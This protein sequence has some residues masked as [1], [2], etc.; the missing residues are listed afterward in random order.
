MSLGCLSFDNDLS[1]KM[2]KQLMVHKQIFWSHR[3]AYYTCRQESTICHFVILAYSLSEIMKQIL[4]AFRILS[5]SDHHFPFS[6][7]KLLKTTDLFF[8]TKFFYYNDMNW[9]FSPVQTRINLLPLLASSWFMIISNL[10]HSPTE[11]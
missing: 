2:Y 4:E 9:N 6:S 11:T 5:S 10:R 3:G 8:F 7:N 1:V